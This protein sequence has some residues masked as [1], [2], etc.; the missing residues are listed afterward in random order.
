MLLSM[1]EE[2]YLGIIHFTAIAND[3]GTELI[4]SRQVIAYGRPGDA[5]LALSTS[6]NSRNIIEALARHLHANTVRLDGPSGATGS[7]IHRPTSPA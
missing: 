7:I 5:L 4:F 3:V 2:I 6:G 1:I